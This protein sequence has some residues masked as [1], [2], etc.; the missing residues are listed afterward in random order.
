M[1]ASMS[2]T[3]IPTW[4]M[5]PNKLIAILAFPYSTTVQTHFAITSRR[6]PVRAIPHR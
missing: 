1:A 6:L 3:T 2:H 5:F 4:R